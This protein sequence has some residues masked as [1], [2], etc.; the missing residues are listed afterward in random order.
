MVP[1]VLSR[2][3]ESSHSS[4]ELPRARRGDDNPGSCISISASARRQNARQTN[5]GNSYST[6][7]RILTPQTLTL[8]R[9]HQSWEISLWSRRA[10]LEAAFSP[11]RSNRFATG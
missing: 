9:Y 2:T 4:F 11:A 1:L 5:Q 10:N 3:E 6:K 7:V 8:V